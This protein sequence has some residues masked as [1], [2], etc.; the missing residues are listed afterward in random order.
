MFL[1]V[2]VCVYLNLMQFFSSFLPIFYSIVHRTVCPAR[3]T[4]RD[5]RPTGIHFLYCR[6]FMRPPF[7]QPAKVIHWRNRHSCQPSCR[8]PGLMTTFSSKCFL[9]FFSSPLPLS[10]CFFLPSSLGW[11][12][13][14]YCHVVFF[15]LQPKAF[16]A[17]FGIFIRDG[18]LFINSTLTFSIGQNM[19]ACDAE[20]LRLRASSKMDS[21]VILWCKSTRVCVCVWQLG[22]PSC[23][24]CASLLCEW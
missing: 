18:F 24:S 10:T 7:W 5:T 21:H 17:G 13:S 22:A 23:H 1:L 4:T 19:T 9:F 20:T 8:C 15:C 12:T 3:T 16:H 2:F 14:F 6:I 11:E